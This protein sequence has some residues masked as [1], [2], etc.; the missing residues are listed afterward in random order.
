[1]TNGNSAA[2]TFAVSVVNLAGRFD[3]TSVAI[4]PDADGDGVPDTTVPIPGPATVTLG[5]GGVFRFVVRAVVPTGAA[6]FSYD[7]LQVAAQSA[8]PGGPRL[9]NIDRVDIRVPGVPQVDVVNVVKSFSVQEGPSPYDAIVVSIGY[10]NTRT[11]RSEFQI[12]D[13]IP[14]GF[15]YVP[16]SA[17]WSGS[18]DTPLTDAEGG[19]PA[20][21]S[22]NFGVTQPGAVSAVLGLLGPNETGTL[23]FRL[24]VAAGLPT[25][26][27]LTNVAKARWTDPSGADSWWR[28]TNPADYRVTGEIAV[29]LTGERIPFAQPGTTVTFNN[30]LTNRGTL[31][32]TFNIVLGTSTFPA[33]TSIR[34]YGPDGTTPLA[35]TNG[36]GI[37]DVGI[38]APGQSVRIVVKAVLPATL[39][40][41][42]YSV[43]KTARSARAATLSAT[44]SD[45]VEAVGRQCRIDLT[46]DNQAQSAYGRHVTYSHYLENR[47][48]CDETVRVVAGFIADSQPGWVSAAYLD[49]AVA[50]GVSIPGVLDSTDTPIVQG[51]TALLAPGQ[52]LRILV[53][54][55]APPAPAKAKPGQGHGR[56]GHHDAHHREPDGRPADGHRQDDHRR[57][58]YVDPAAERPA[59]FHGRGLPGAHRLGGAWRHGVAPR[60]CR[61]LQRR[62]GRRGIA[63]DRHHRFQRGTGGG[64]RHR[65]GTGH[66]D[67]RGARLAGARAAR[68]RGRSHPAGARIRRP[69][70]RGPRLRSRHRDLDHADGAGWR[71]LRQRHQRAGPRRHGDPC[72][73]LRR[74]LLGHAGAHERQ[75][76]HHR[77]RWPLRIPVRPRR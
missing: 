58:G 16:G 23:T 63:N 30:L 8:T 62:S 15:T 19:D 48:N 9:E 31:A 76:R 66:R 41:G 42:E 18:G 56:D 37:P 33:G 70:R 17:R 21:I 59:Q 54:V 75:S 24:R 53:D 50:G 65:D 35:D 26:E 38:V 68:G 7:S 52:K 6:P 69:R 1:M 39:V 20:G 49:N 32:E 74:A 47:G 71:R 55:M 61:F 2:D 12:L 5:P 57:H 25:G 27:V 67:L 45:V 40:P 36:D 51:W 73:G 22:Y 4:L 72:P 46:P 11:P 29:T 10:G 34:L 77:V 13:E 3:F 14:A 44:A 28:N 64:S 43:Q 60:G